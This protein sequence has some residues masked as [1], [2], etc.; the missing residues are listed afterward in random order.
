MTPAGALASRAVPRVSEVNTHRK[1]R[2]EES[3]NPFENTS[4]F[5]HIFFLERVGKWASR[6]GAV[7][8]GCCAPPPLPQAV[9][10]TLATVGLGASG[11]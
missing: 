7:A 5:M 3:K 4:T 9:A 1:K 8:G 11:A 2:E 6:L 10:W